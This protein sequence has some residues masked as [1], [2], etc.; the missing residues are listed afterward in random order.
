MFAMSPSDPEAPRKVLVND[1]PDSEAQ[2]YF[3][4]PTHQLISNMFPAPTL[5]QVFFARFL[6]RAAR[7]QSILPDEGKDTVY[8]CTKSIATLGKELDLSNDTVQKYV[9][10]Y[11]AL[12]FLRKRKVL[13]QL[14]FVMFTGIY[15]P[16][17]N[18]EAN[19][20]FL[21]QKSRPKLR[22]MAIEV[23]TRCQIYGLI[24]QD[25]IHS[26]EQLQALLQMEKGTPLRTLERRLTQAQHLTSRL[27]RTASTLHLPAESPQVGRSGRQKEGDLPLNLPSGGYLRESIHPQE[28]QESTRR[29]SRGRQRKEGRSQNLLNNASS[30]DSSQDQQDQETLLEGRSGRS[31]AHSASSRLP[32]M[33]FQED[34]LQDTQSKESPH[35]SIF[36][37]HEE[38]HSS[39]RLPRKASQVVST[40]D[41]QV[42]AS[43]ENGKPGRHLEENASS[44]LPHRAGWVDSGIGNQQKNIAEPI[45]IGEEG[46]REDNH[47]RSNLPDH[48]Q[49]V[50]SGWF[51]RNVN[52]E[53]TYQFITTFT[54]REP[55]RVAEFLANQLEGDRR[56]FPKYQKLFHSQDGQPRDPHIL[57]AA[58]I[59][60][61]VRLHRDR[62]NI[63]N[64]PG[65]FFTKRCWEYDAGVPEEVEGWI[66]SYGHLSPAELLEVLTKQV[67]AGTV[68]TIPAPSKPASASLLPPLT[69]ASQ[70]QVEPEHMV[71]SKDEAQALVQSIRHDTRTSLFRARCIR[72]GKEGSRYA[73]LVDASVPGGKPHQSVVYTCAEWRRRLDTMK[74]WRDLI[75]PSTPFPLPS[76]KET[77]QAKGEREK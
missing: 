14:A 64:R 17:G 70:I 37:R 69:L 71:M 34:S 62:W 65:G 55:Q 50:D 24:S 4:R 45:Q 48:V 30:V 47:L 54:L 3:E 41:K 46:R 73:V 76:C 27:I 28:N 68:S 60:T 21:I 51:S 58:F 1:P 22:A 33:M 15:R 40:Q 74:T 19:L 6:E 25:L 49:R 77:Y 20:D 18:L 29:Q 56:V 67:Q 31:H 10:L 36:S 7:E 32:N 75:Y 57:A 5:G 52:V 35:N 59:C 2:G 43:I 42:S 23:K 11:I 44:R 72:L 8:I 26:L 61:L 16:P 38:E 53:N 9:V 13:G 66:K 39:S 12:G 63:S